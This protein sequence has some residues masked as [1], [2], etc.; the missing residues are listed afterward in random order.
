MNII[1]LIA[2]SYVI[3]YQNGS[4]AILPKAIL[5]FLVGLLDDKLKIIAPIPY[6]DTYKWASVGISKLINYS[7]DCNFCFNFWIS[8]ILY[9][10][11]FGIDGLAYGVIYSV[12]FNKIVQRLGLDSL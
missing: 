6:Q 7:I 1:I 4:I 2:I 3:T 8:Y 5:K 11:K 10:H 12:L 9:F